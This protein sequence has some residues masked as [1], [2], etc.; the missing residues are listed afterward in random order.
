M[1]SSPLFVRQSAVST[2]FHSSPLLKH[3]TTTSY[4]LRPEAQ[5]GITNVT[6][7]SK[8]RAPGLSNGSS[9][10]SLTT[11]SL[12]NRGGERK[13]G[14]HLRTVKRLSSGTA[15]GGKIKCIP[16]CLIGQYATAS[17]LKI[18]KRKTSNFCFFFRFW[19]AE[20]VQWRRPSPSK[21]VVW[22]RFRTPSHICTELVDSTIRT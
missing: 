12:S 5:C 9:M 16:A 22:V 1:V 14:F 13:R 17:P 15:P 4:P 2:S 19:R 21:N 3:L 10:T 8:C 6:V 11:A 18:K 7:F 20:M